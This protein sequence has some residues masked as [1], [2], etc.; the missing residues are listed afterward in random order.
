MFFAPAQVRKR[1]GDWG[2]HGLNARL[3]ASW[4]AFC[5]E[6]HSSQ[7]PWLVVQQHVGPQAAQ[8]LFMELLAGHSDPRIGHIA[9][10][11]AA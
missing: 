6:A 5:K 10:L 1:N 2:A 7:T 11:Q 8:A 4:E 3:I 9:S